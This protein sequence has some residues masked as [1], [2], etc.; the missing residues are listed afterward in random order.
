MLKPI[1][2]LTCLQSALLG[3]SPADDA[4]G[5]PDAPGEPGAPG[6]YYVDPAGRDL[7]P[8]TESEPFL[9]IERA[10]EEVRKRV[11][12]GLD[13][14][15]TIVLREG[16]HRLKTPFVLGPEDSGTKL[17]SI[18]YAAHPGERP[19]LS[20]GR[21][22]TG[23]RKGEGQI[24]TAEVPLA[25]D[26]AWTFRQLFV[27]GKRRQRA[28]TPNEGY[29]RIVGPSSQDKPFRLAFR[30][31][32]IRKGWTEGG[33]EVEVIAL[34]SWAEIRMQIAEVDEARR[35][36]I[37]SG[38]PRPSNRE[39]NARYWIENAPDGL[40]APGEWRLDTKAGLLHYW[41]VPGEDMKGAE[42][43]APVLGELVRIE[44]DLPRVRLVR[45][46]RFQGIAFAHTDWTLGPRGY[47]DTQAAVEIGGAFSASGAVGCSIV[48]CTFTLLGGYGIQLSGGCQKN[49]LVGNEIVDVGGGGIKVGETFQRPN[50]EESTH[51]NVITDNLLH[52]CGRVYPA[53]VGVWIAQSSD[54]L[55]A[56]NEI[57]DL[58]YTA[59]SVGWTWGY[60]PNRSKGNRIEH[61]HLHHIGQGVLS[62]MGGIYTLGVQP[63]TVLRNNLIHHVE[64]F[65]YG[66]WGIYPDEGSSEILIEDNVVYACKSSGF[67]Q[68]YGRDNVV[69]NNIFAMNSENQLMRTRA[70]DHKSFTFE[71]N[72]I[73]WSTGNLLGG[74]WSGEGYSFDRNLYWL[75]GG[76]PIRF[77]SWSI[78]QWR[79]KGQDAASAIADPL[80]VNVTEG[81]YTLRPES[82]AFRLGFEAID[83]SSVGPRPPGLR[84]DLE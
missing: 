15:V 60:G 13:R 73:Y 64:A 25:R 84:I 57:S 72:I 21:R 45:N 16:V 42:V 9:T 61:N 69:R 47:A 31:G 10:R 80:F 49:S 82:P 71:R 62:D 8:G 52:R 30:P 65:A 79:E 35:V 55:I 27:D 3:L 53:A 5:D 29:Y 14:N 2:L 41:P 46:V 50:H 28:R 4:P 6:D 1:C 36:A 32:D 12:A 23:F 78:D 59:I 77:G 18:T 11:A 54:N 66:G 39:E 67:H 24:W 17:H 43:I 19:V 38:D 34:L 44:A 51:G 74:N 7:N 26:G 37:L 33:E 40:D 81:D 22:I 48:D 83:L 58:Y 76:R 63:G 75:T 68:H 56:H 20:G 70:E